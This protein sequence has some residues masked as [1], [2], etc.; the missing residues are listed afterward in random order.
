M[1][2]EPGKLSLTFDGV[3]DVAAALT[4]LLPLRYQPAD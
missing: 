4:T 1:K 3:Y 2:E